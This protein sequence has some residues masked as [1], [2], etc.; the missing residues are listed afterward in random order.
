MMADTFHEATA[1]SRV[2]VKIACEEVI[3]MKNRIM[4][5]PWDSNN[6]MRR[7]PCVTSRIKKGMKSVVINPVDQAKRENPTW[8]FS[9]SV[10]GKC[11][12]CLALWMTLPQFKKTVALKRPWAIKWNTASEKAPKPHSMI[13]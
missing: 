11:G 3:Q 4:T 5:V 8:S 1:R 2:S 13:M 10:R 6:G 9:W 7:T 12:S